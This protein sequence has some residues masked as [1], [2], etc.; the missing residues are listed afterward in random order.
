MTALLGQDAAMNTAVQ[1]PLA[2]VSTL[3][4]WDLGRAGIMQLMLKSCRFST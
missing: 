4:R 3:P 2:A 1:P